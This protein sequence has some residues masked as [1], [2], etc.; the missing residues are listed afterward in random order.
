VAAVAALD[1]TT[2]DVVAVT[3]STADDVVLTLRSGLQVRWGGVEDAA[4][5]AE[6]LHAALRKAAAGATRIDVS[7]PGVVL[8]H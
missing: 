7:S 4:G 2:P 6:A 3:A 8:T 5:K 1:G